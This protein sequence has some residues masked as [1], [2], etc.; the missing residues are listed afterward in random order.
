MRRPL[1][2]FI[3]ILLGFFILFNIMVINH[4]YKFTHFYDIGEV[5][6]IP[7]NQKT[8]SQVFSEMFF[9]IKAQKRP[10]TD[11]DS[12]SSIIKTTTPDEIELESVTIKANAAKGTVLMVHG[13]GSNKSAL[14]PQAM[15]F[16]QMGY[17][18]CLTDLRA[19]G[20]SGGNTSTIGFNEA[21][22]V[23]T[24]YDL[25]KNEGEKN[26]ILYGISL[27]AATISRSIAIDSIR[28]TKVILEMP[29]AS[30]EEAVEGR[31]ALMKLPKEPISTLLTFWGGTI[32]GFWAFSMEPKEYVKQMKCPVLLQWGAQDPRVTRK[33]IE[34][35][36][37]NIPTKKQLVVYENSGH[38]NLFLTERDKWLSNV[39]SFLEQ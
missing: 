20:S 38:Q 15:A 19:H 7:Q 25:L 16:V 27:G 35:I 6:S 14:Y 4:A 30:L 31:V 32:H 12:I 17:N 28:P 33:E 9:G 36:F 26:I 13:H 18:V 10:N 37:A 11:M 21:I 34:D 39:K 3:T 29:F 1:K 2:I 22:D 5:V 8:K 24:M 23:T